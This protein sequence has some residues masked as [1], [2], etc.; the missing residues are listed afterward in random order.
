M[1]VGDAIGDGTQR[2][3]GIISIMVYAFVI[4]ARFLCLRYVENGYLI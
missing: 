2:D 4:H 1:K 3:L